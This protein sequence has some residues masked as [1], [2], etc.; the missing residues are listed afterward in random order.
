MKQNGHLNA[1]FKISDRDPAGRKGN[2]LL[3]VVHFVLVFGI[4]DV[5][6]VEEVSFE[7]L[8]YV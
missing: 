6:I 5:L 8:G 7:E 2:S 4:V 1:W 3:E